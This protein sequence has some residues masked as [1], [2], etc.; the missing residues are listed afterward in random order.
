MNV[1][2]SFEHD[3][4]K[5]CHQGKARHIWNSV[6]HDITYSVEWNSCNFLYGTF[7]TFEFVMFFPKKGS[8]GQSD[9]F[10]AQ[11]LNIFCMYGA[12]SSTAVSIT[13]AEKYF[14]F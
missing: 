13:Q 3:I 12:G 9:E 2:P 1:W 7:C 4:G 11:L 14:K 5:K 8:E 6:G 10:K